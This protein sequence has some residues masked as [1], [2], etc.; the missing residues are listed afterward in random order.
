[1]GKSGR[2]ELYDYPRRLELCLEH[3]RKENGIGEENIREIETFS[4]IRLA[5]GSGYGRVAKVV[6]CIRF[7][8]RWLGKPF[9]EA[10]KDDLIALVG[11]LEAKDYAEY[12]YL[13]GEI[14]GLTAVE[15][16]LQNLAK[17]LEQIDDE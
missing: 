14:R 11:G 1:M 5:K 3:L 16:Y 15:M 7:L 10:T 12:K 17:N 8:A 9:R 6:Y 2:L 4:K 13:C